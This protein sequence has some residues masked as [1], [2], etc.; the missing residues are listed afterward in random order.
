MVK[1]QSNVKTI[2]NGGGWGTV[3]GAEYVPGGGGGWSLGTGFREASPAVIAWPLQ[4]P[5]ALSFQRR[6]SGSSSQS[7]SMGSSQCRVGSTMPGQAG[8]S[9]VLSSTGSCKAAFVL[10][11]T[12]MS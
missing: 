11:F 2:I 5:R 4:F 1:M 3:L 8:L 7:V 10:A 9:S 6:L 12:M